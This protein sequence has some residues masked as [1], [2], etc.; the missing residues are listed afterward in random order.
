MKITNIQAVCLKY[1][2]ERPIAD[3]CTVCGAR[4]SVLVRVNTDTQL[5]GLGEAATFGGSLDA[6]KVIIER[7]LAPLLVG[8]DPLDIE[9]LWNKLMWNNWSAGR[10]GMVMG[11]ISGIDIALWDLLGKAAGM[12]LYR[13][14]G[15]NAHRVKGYASAGFYAPGKEI[16]DLERELESYCA[17]GFSDFKMKIGRVQGGVN[18]PLRYMNQGDWAYTQKQDAARIA[19]ARRVIG[20]GARLMVDMNCT[21]DPDAVVAGEQMFSEYGVYWVEEPTRSDDARSYARIAASLKSTLVA[22]IESEQGLARYSELV[23]MG[24]LDVVQANLGWAGGITEARRIAALALAHGKMFTPHTFFSAVLNAAKVQF[25]A[26]LSNV[27]FIECELNPNPLRT[28][29]LKQNLEMDEHMCFIL[30]Q[31]PG[32]GIEVDWEKAERYLYRG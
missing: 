4:S 26:S 29:L 19:A 22:G 6:M 9:R 11:G 32:L 1:P 27:P 15:A 2:Y 14:L 24:A 7:Q 13:L 23:E 25:A 5:Y 12:P 20:P 10:R 8:E 17:M 31:G 18:S 21:W 30:P 16:A 28:D 3:G